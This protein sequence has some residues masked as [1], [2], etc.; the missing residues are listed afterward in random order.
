[1]IINAKYIPANLKDGTLDPFRILEYKI[2]NREWFFNLHRTLN[3]SLTLIGQDDYIAV[4]D[5]LIIDA[6][7]IFPGQNTNEDHIANKGRAFFLAHI[8]SVSHNASVNEVGARTFTTEIQFVR[9]VITDKNGNQ[10][11]EDVYL[12]ENTHD[13]TP[14]Q[15]LNQ[16]RVF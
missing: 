6:D 2:M 12:D 1:M 14:V 4:G 16:N 15:E 5:N 3:G 10:I 9:G 7:A 11:K 8:E 13:V